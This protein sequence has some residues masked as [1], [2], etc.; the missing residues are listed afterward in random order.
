[1]DGRSRLTPLDLEAL[2]SACSRLSLPEL[3]PPLGLDR[4]GIAELEAIVEPVGPLYRGDYLFRQGDRFRAIYAV[5]S[6]YLKTYRE[7]KDGDEDALGFFMSGELLGLDSINAGRTRGSAVVLETA[8]VWRLPFDML[9]DACGRVPALQTQL[10][11]LMSR[12]LTVSKLLSESHSVETRMAGFLL[13]WGDRMAQRD[14]SRHHL[15]LPMSRQDIGNY[16]RLAPESVSRC[17]HRFSDRGWIEVSGREVRLTQPRSLAALCS[18][19][20]RV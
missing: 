19:G 9:S 6:G 7:T 11:Q 16:L 3:W 13:G 2:R 14:F 17:L 18:D 20:W 12:E 8:M 15:V 4:D 5:R 10:L 1:M